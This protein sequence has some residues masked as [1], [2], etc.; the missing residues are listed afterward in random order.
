MIL[1]KNRKANSIISAFQ[2]MFDIHK[3]AGFNFPIRSI[4]FDK[5]TSVLSNKVQDFLKENNVSFVA[6][7]NTSSKSK[8]AENAIKQ[9]RTIMARLLRNNQNNIRW[10]T[11]LPRVVKILNSR[12]IYVNGKATGFTPEQ[13]NNNN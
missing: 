1:R 2:R 4:S 8:I 12:Q 9:I 7:K 6:F 3:A 11:L 5:E 10:W 13:I